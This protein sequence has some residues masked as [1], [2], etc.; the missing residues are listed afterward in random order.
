MGKSYQSK[1]VWIPKRVKFSTEPI[2][3]QL[4]GILRLNASKITIHHKNNGITLP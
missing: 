4:Y 2:I 3:L 1:T